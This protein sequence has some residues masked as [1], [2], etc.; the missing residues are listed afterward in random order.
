METESPYNTYKYAGLPPG[1]VRMPSIQVIDAV[2][3][4][5]HHDYMFFCAKSDFSGTHHFSRTLR[6]HN[7]YAA[8]YHQA[9]N[10][11]KIY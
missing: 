2:L 11:R 1:P 5:Q 4:Y 7:Q 9:L 8:E 10:K 6:Q 3:D